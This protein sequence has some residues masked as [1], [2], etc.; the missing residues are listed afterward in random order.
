M[1]GGA[2]YYDLNID[3]WSKYPQNNLKEYLP[4]QQEM[5]W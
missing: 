3:I 2:E 5:K 1:G 4:A